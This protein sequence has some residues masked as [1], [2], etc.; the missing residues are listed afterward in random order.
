MGESVKKRAATYRLSPEALELIGALVAEL[1][2][3]QAGI[4]EMA[5]RDLATARGLR[6]NASTRA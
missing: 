1:G 6:G 4:V 2:L 3:S 5:I